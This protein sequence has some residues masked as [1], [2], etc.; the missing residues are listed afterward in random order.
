MTAQ[1][2]QGAGSAPGEGAGQAPGEGA[3]KAP[4]EGV[5]AAGDGAGRPEGL[6]R[7]EEPV[8]GYAITVPSA[9]VA[10]LNTVDPLARLM[11]QLDGKDLD[12]ESKLTG[13][14]PVG[15]A[16]AEVVDDIGEGHHEPLRLLEFDVLTRPDPLSDAEIATMRGAV[17]DGM[18]EALASRGM[19]GFVFSEV[20]DARLGPLEALAFE[21]EWAGP[22]EAPELI[23]RALVVW[24]PTPT[25]VYQVYY[26]CPA[27]VW[28][29]WLPE[30]EQILASFELTERRPEAEPGQA[31]EPRTLG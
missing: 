21:Y 28:D 25:A 27:E 29:A 20:W 2:N 3:G 19:P 10:L 31:P 9:F 15:F 8:Y 24:A 6:R 30:F 17:R 13:S 7:H 23:D 1:Q 12:Q 26:H 11:R 4:G 22:R 14:W 5:A 18:P 16:D